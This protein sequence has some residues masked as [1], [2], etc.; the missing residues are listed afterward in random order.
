MWKGG[1]VYFSC[2]NINPGMTNCYKSVSV[3]AAKE[4]TD[5][6][7]LFLRFCEE[8]QLNGIIYSCDMLLLFSC[9]PIENK[10]YLIQLVNSETG[11]LFREK[12][13]RQKILKRRISD[14]VLM[15]FD[16]I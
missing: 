3:L 14:V 1:N 8:L 7:F 16:N 4:I 9:R 12:W 5:F 15:I 2:L 11:R 6:F 10:W 13:K